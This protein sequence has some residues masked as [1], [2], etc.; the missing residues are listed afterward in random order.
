LFSASDLFLRS[1]RKIIARIISELWLYL[2]SSLSKLW[3]WF[4]FSRQPTILRT[5]NFV[6]CA[7]KQKEVLNK[8]VIESLKYWDFSTLLWFERY[9]NVQMGL[10]SFGEF[11]FGPTVLINMQFSSLEGQP[12]VFLNSLGSIQPWTWHKIGFVTG[13]N[14]V[15][16]QFRPLGLR[17]YTSDVLLYTHTRPS[18]CLSQLPREYPALNMA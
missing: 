5:M 12:R 6:K 8:W 1:S 9:I 16:A 11:C 13:F 17:T 18:Q 14:I 4:G 2:N 7:E 3:M 15:Q 10:W